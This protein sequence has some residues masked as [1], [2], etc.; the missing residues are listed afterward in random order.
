MTPAYKTKNNDENEYA[1]HF[2]LLAI[3]LPCR[4]HHVRTFCM[5]WG[6]LQHLLFDY[7][8][9]ISLGAQQLAIGGLGAE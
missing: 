6:R 9:Y 1:T 7:A 2:A 4:L 3:G 5:R 8:H